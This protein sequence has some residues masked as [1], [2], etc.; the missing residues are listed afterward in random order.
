MFLDKEKRTINGFIDLIIKEFTEAGFQFSLRQG[1][2]NDDII[3]HK[4]DRTQ[5]NSFHYKKT[6]N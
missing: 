3:D 4:V 2:F 5:M 6:S 1:L